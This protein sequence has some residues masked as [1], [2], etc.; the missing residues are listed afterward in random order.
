MAEYHVIDEL[1]SCLVT[2]GIV[3]RWNTT[4]SSTIP[5][6]VIGP[7]G[8]VTPICDAPKGIPA[9]WS[10]PA[11]A[12]PFGIVGGAMAALGCCAPVGA[13]APPCPSA[14]STLLLIPTS[15]W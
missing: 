2:A 15:C 3:Q 9:P 10:A 1:L 11:A 4:P 13:G 8:I 14:S 5:G 7:L 6:A 12:V